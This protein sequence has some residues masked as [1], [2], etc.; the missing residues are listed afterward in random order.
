MLIAMHDQQPIMLTR[1]KIFSYYFPTEI[2]KPF[3]DDHTLQ[4][5]TLPLY[6]PMQDP[7]EDSEDNVFITTETRV[8]YCAEL[9]WR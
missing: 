3:A 2:Y 6:F 1:R 4:K 7:V 5:R 9:H 8:N